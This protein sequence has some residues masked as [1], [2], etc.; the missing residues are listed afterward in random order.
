MP[1]HKKV[2]PPETSG[3][4]LGFQAKQMANW[5]SGI[6]GF[7]FTSNSQLK[8]SAPKRE[9]GETLET[10]F[11]KAQAIS[12]CVLFSGGS[13]FFLSLTLSHFFFLT[14]FLSL[15]LSFACSLSLSLSLSHLSVSLCPCTR[16]SSVCKGQGDCGLGPCVPF[17]A[18]PRSLDRSE[19]VNT[20]ATRD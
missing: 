1:R 6:T 14:L 16:V 12:V 11:G 10:E 7:S 2:S 3:V 19:V 8:Q 5:R 18:A 4:H 17:G 15:P 9:M 13:Y 20:P